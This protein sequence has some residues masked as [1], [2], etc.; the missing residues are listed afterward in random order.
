[1]HGTF[2]VLKRGLGVFFFEKYFLALILTKTNL[3]Q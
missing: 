3:S 1:M 2:D